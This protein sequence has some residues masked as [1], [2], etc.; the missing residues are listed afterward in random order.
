MYISFLSTISLNFL[1]KEWG[2]D[3]ILGIILFYFQIK[4]RN[5]DRYNIILY[6]IVNQ[7]WDK[8]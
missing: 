5:D 7:T 3:V 4:M 8:I 1:Y 6:L 2:G